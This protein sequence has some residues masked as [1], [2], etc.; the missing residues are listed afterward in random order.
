MA[1][2]VE[3][4]LAGTPEKLTPLEVAQLLDVD[5]RSVTRWLNAGQLAG[6]KI[7]G[8]WIVPRDALEAMLRAGDHTQH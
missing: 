2:H 8:R 4:L 5:V 1:D 6:Y 3:V 7:G